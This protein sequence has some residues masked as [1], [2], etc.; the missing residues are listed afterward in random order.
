M[1]II[2]SVNKTRLVAFNN[3]A[4]K[5]VIAMNKPHFNNIIIIRLKN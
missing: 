4:L 1:S 3:D 5:Y 2:V